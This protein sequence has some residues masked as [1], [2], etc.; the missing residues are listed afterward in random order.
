MRRRNRNLTRLGVAALAAILLGGAA[1]A[2]RG[3]EVC[4]DPLNTEPVSPDNFARVIINPMMFV[5]VGVAGTATFGGA[6]GPC[7]IPAVTQAQNGFLFYG[8]GNTGSLHSGTDDFCVQV[9][10][11]PWGGNDWAFASVRVIDSDGGTTDSRFE[12]YSSRTGASGR[13]MEAIATIEGV[14]VQLLVTVAGATSRWQWTLT[15]QNAGTVQ[16]GLRYAAWSAML[17]VFFNQ[18]GR[19]NRNYI[20]LNTG[21]PVELERDTLRSA[22][23]LGFPRHMEFM[24]RQSDP[25]P[26]VRVL[27]G[28]TSVYTDQ[29]QADRIVIGNAATVVGTEGNPVLWNSSIIPDNGFGPTGYALFFN[30]T[31]LAPGQSRRITYYIEQGWSTNVFSTPDTSGA[32]YTLTVEAPRLITYNPG[33]GTNDMDPNPFY[34][35]AWVDNMYP[36][37]ANDQTQQLPLTNVNYT[38]TL[39]PGITF[40]TGESATKSIPNIDPLEVREVRWRV[41]AD[42]NIS[43]P[44]KYRVSTTSFPGG[45]NTAEGIIN[46]SATPKLNIVSGP[47]LIVMPWNF[48]DS[49]I[50][51]VTGRTIGVDFLGYFNWNVTTQSYELTT[52]AER[53]RGQWLVSNF[54]FPGNGLAGASS[55][56][57][58]VGGNFPFRIRRGWNLIGNPY[59]YQVTLNQIWA[60]DTAQPGR[61]RTWDELVNLGKVRGVLFRY[62]TNVGN[63]LFTSDP[64]QPL[65]PHVG[66]WIY[67]N[68][69]SDID[70]FWPPIFAPGLPGSSRSE[71]WVVTENKWRLQITARGNGLTDVSNYFGVA[72]TS[73]E[74]EKLSLPEPPDA[75]SAKFRLSGWREGNEIENWAQDIRESRGRITYKMRFVAH[76]PGSYTLAWPNISQLPRS[77]RAR[78]LDKE[79]GVS[80]DLRSRSS[81]SFTMPSAGGRTFELVIEPGTATRPVIGG[82]VISGGGR[83]PAAQISIQYSLSA[84]ADVG[85]RILS[86]TGREISVL[87][88]SSAMGPGNNVVVWNLRDLR[89]KAVAPGTY[90][91]EIVA[92]TP[93]GQRVRRT[94]PVIVTR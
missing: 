5:G 17:N 47:Q 94:Q 77:V 53:G 65:P 82:V 33:G 1:Q 30:P 23:P 59:P 28:P 6:T 48:V 90:M 91:V 45:N 16:A 10:G 75:P 38:L 76:E 35:T 32:P 46:L 24:F 64:T 7:F 36:Q 43:G 50:E 26:S 74:A 83:G 42:G 25:Y 44:V 67:V 13:Y 14:Q 70:L 55:A 58:E 89:G 72:P 68:S 66:F 63:Y 54:D 84:S 88:A 37:Y 12:G 49:N 8:T 18:S 20:M 27:L 71:D 41:V 2:Q 80:R 34:I 62:D 78:I 3:W 85:V 73:S 92:Q 11:A 60:V 87:A 56:G 79:T 9:M 61:I 52:S 51:T 15:N 81:Y 69:T 93:E 40:A 29:S 86:T 22:N 19:T 21:R 4:F 39:P 57:D 31:L